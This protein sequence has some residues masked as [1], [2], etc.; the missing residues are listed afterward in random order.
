MKSTPTNA[1]Q[2]ECVDPPLQIRRQFLCDR[3]VGKM[4]QLSSHPLWSRLNE[5]S[6]IHNPNKPE[7]CLLNSFLFFTKLPNPYIQ[8]PLN[9]LFSIP[10]KAL[11]YRPNIVTNL[12]FVKGSPNTKTLF[13][14][15]VHQNWSDHL[16]I[17]TD[18]SKLSADSCVG[19]ACWI[20]KFKI[21][22]QFKCPPESSIF[23]GEAVAILEAILYAHS[24][25][26]RQTVILTDSLSCLLA[27]KE[28]P[29]RSRKRFF[30]ILKIREVL[31]FCHQKGLQITLVW[32][33]SHSGIPGNESA[34]SCA[35]SA[36]QL[37]SHDHF[38]NSCH[39][40]CN[41]ANTRLVKS[42]TSYWISSRLIKGK[43][44]ASLQPEIPKRPWFFRFRHADRWVTSTICR[45]RLG[46]A[47]T[48]T[49][50]AKIRVRDHSLCECGLDEGS[51]S[52]IL[53]NCPNLIHPLYDV[54][55]PE[56][57]RPT[58]RSEMR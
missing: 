7:S 12:G 49:H 35:K 34:D 33:P 40:L 54:L 37:G 20:P 52:H 23:T 27:I 6:Q 9:P 15:V 30:I 44:Y 46:H 42:W 32:I 53:F 13:N 31:F 38:K 4:L 26:I 57:P 1:L 51:T 29:F 17:Y 19:A 43:Y 16:L 48:P 8:L 5:L 39:D 36:I 28:N 2:V 58:L 25:D 55:P 24:H 21:I 11:V 41:A 10:Y 3:F 22:L 14:Y 47:C 50:L 45:L 56:V 18:A